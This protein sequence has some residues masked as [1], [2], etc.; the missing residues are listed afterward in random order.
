MANAPFS[1]EFFLFTDAPAK[2][3][4]LKNTVTG[5]IERT[6][7]VVS[8]ALHQAEGSRHT[9]ATARV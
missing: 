8:G 9:D 2:D 7:S 6:Q 1:S 3:K 4:E 5:L